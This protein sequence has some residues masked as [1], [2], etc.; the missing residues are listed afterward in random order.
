MKPSHVA[1][2]VFIS[3]AVGFGLFY[4]I[5]PKDGFIEE[6]KR[7]YEQYRDSLN[8]I[9]ERLLSEIDKSKKYNDSLYLANDSIQ[10]KI[11]TLDSSL[12]ALR[13]K[14]Y[15]DIN[16]IDD[17]SIDSNIIILSRFLSKEADNRE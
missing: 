8:E 12:N 10:S 3:M 1:V 2:L 15:E 13:R 5:T 6:R 9:N 4:L 17:I 16:S 7:K 11:N 14:H